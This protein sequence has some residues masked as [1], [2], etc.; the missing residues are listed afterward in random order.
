MDQQL[1]NVLL[2]MNQVA[3]SRIDYQAVEDLRH[4]LSVIRENLRTALS[5]G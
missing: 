4:G 3:E 5:E 1:M 2:E